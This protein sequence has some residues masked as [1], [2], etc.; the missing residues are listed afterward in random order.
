VKILE[1]GRAQQGWS[2]E[3]SC[4]GDGNGGGGCGARLLVEQPDLYLTQSHARDET[5]TFVTFE[6]A[7]CGVETDL[8]DV[9]R[10][11]MDT[12]RVRRR[13]T[14]TDVR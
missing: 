12:L 14:G 2:V 1:P 8:K 6:C 4:T 11:V 13:N 9:P 10:N 7:A 5:D 3:T